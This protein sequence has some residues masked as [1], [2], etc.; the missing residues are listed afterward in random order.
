MHYMH[1]TTTLQQQEGVLYI[2]AP[3]PTAVRR[4]TSPMRRLTPFEEWLYLLVPVPMSFL[5]TL[6]LLCG[7]FW[8]LLLG[9]VT[10]H[11]YGN[12]C[13]A[14]LSPLLYLL[15]GACLCTA[16]AASKWCVLGRQHDSVHKLWSWYHYRTV[17]CFHVYVKS[18]MLFGDLLRGGA[19]FNLYLSMHGG[20]VSSS[21]VV[22]SIRVSGESNHQSLLLSLVILLQLCF[23]HDACVV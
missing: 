1:T 23:A 2:G 16:A 20:H 14:L 21:A 9:A 17:L 5:S 3:D 6:I 4:Y 10:A 13:A 18:M 12:V 15:F 11:R 8:P 22:N 7:A 19:L